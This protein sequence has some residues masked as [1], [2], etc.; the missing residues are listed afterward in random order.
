MQTQDGDVLV[1]LVP[2]ISSAM[3]DRQQGRYGAASSMSPL[4]GMSR[5]SR[6]G[7]VIMDCIGHEPDLL[8]SQV[9]VLIHTIVH[10]RII[11]YTHICMTRSGHTMYLRLTR[12]PGPRDG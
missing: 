8:L 2:A 3:S 11:R 1:N 5:S 9:Q 4:L 12:C 7:E 10:S 6:E